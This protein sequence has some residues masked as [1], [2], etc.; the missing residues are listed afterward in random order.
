MPMAAH[1]TPANLVPWEAWRTDGQGHL[2]ID[3]RAAGG[4]KGCLPRIVGHWVGQ[5]QGQR[6]QVYGINGLTP[7]LMLDDGRLKEVLIKDLRGP[8][9][10]VRLLSELE[11]WK[12]HGGSDDEWQRSVRA[13]GGE[14]TLRSALRAFPPNSALA[15]LGW[16][17]RCTN[18]S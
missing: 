1:L 3:P 6:Q 13:L 12:L 4:R 8:P 11:A 7:T 5:R 15:V 14:E 10:Q 2:R 16:W 18:P 17:L 9:P